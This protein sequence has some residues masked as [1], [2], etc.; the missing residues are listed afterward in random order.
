MTALSQLLGTFLAS[1]AKAR[2]IAD[3]QTAAIAEQYRHNPLLEGL[4]VP[5]VRV[6]ELRIDLPLLI[7]GTSPG[8]PVRYPEPKII[9]H[10]V[11]STITEAL[12]AVDI[13][14]PSEVRKRLLDRLRANL[15]NT[16]AAH[17]DSLHK[18]A[19]IR[20]AEKTSRA[21]LRASTLAERLDA[22]RLQ[23]V[24]EEVRH[25]V[26]E[27]AEVE[28]GEPAEIQVSPVSG[29]IKEC[30]SPGVVA[31]LSLAVKEEGL[32][33]EITRSGDGTTRRRLGPE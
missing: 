25:R 18:E 17:R 13:G 32:E 30:L 21:V 33:W 1:V 20:Q 10:E 3:L 16:M 4:S 24:L 27:R 28:P 29:E 22:E 12:A 26:G 11:V 6:P 5:R 15:R 23:Q 2:H 19:I 7:E 8:S 14:M 9:A 31:R